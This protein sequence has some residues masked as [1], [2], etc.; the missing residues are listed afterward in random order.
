MKIKGLGS[1]ISNWAFGVLI[2]V[3]WL[4]IE[5]IGRYPIFLDMSKNIAES[6]G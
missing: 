2:M 6:R 5:K 1:M 4:V 3:A